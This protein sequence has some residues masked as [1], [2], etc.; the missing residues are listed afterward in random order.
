MCYGKQLRYIDW[1]LALTY[2]YISSISPDEYTG[3]GIKKEKSDVIL[4]I[5]SVYYIFS[6]NPYP[7]PYHY[8]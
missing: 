8:C 5:I 2:I 4:S 6:K 7:Y 1:M 3:Y